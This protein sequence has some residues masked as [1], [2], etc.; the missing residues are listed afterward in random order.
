MLTTFGESCLF[1][2]DP[3]KKYKGSDDL[4]HLLRQVHQNSKGDGQGGADGGTKGT[5]Q[6]TRKRPSGKANRLPC[7]SVKKASCPRRKSCNYWHVPEC[8]KFKA[9]FGCSFGDKS[10]YQH[11][12]KP[13]L[14][15]AF[16]RM[17]N[18][19]CKY[20]KFSRMTKPNTE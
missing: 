2:H 1:K 5:P 14:L 7:T 12:A 20:G 10:A 11:T 13:L 16:H 17:M 15:L 8:A 9:P 18:D 6:F 3:N 19:R 4:V